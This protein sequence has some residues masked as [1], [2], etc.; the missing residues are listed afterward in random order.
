[1]SLDDL[2]RLPTTGDEAYGQETRQTQT[3]SPDETGQ[4]R[5]VLTATGAPAPVSSNAQKAYQYFL[6]KGLARHQ[7]A[8]LVGNLMQESGADLDPTAANPSGA[9]GIAQWMGERKQTLLGKAGADTLEGQL[10]H[11]WDELSGSEREALAQLTAAETPEAAALAVRRQYE[12]PGEL[13]ANDARRLQNTYA[14]LGDPR[15]RTEASSGDLASSLGRYQTA[16]GQSFSEGFAQENTA[17]GFTLTEKG[18]RQ[19][20]SG[21]DLLRPARDTEETSSDVFTAAVRE[22]SV[23][24]AFGQFYPGATITVPDKTVRKLSVT[25]PRADALDEDA[26][27]V[28][29]STLEALVGGKAAALADKLVFEHPALIVEKKG[30]NQGKPLDVPFTLDGL[31]RIGRALTPGTFEDSPASAWRA[32]LQGVTHLVYDQGFRPRG[33]NL[34][35]PQALELWIKNRLGPQHVDTRGEAAGKRPMALSHPALPMTALVGKP[36]SLIH[37]IARGLN[38]PYI[39]TARAAGTLKPT[40][41]LW[42]GHTKPTGLVQTKDN[43]PMYV[44][45]R[46]ELASASPNA[47]ALKLR[48]F[49]QKLG[50]ER[51]LIQTNNSEEAQTVLGLALGVPTRRVGGK[52]IGTQ[53][54]AGGVPHL[55]GFAGESIDPR[56]AP[57]EARST[58]LRD[59]IQTALRARAQTLINALP[60]AASPAEAD[61]RYAAAVRQAA[62]ELAPIT[63]SE[64]KPASAKGGA[65]VE[66]N[67]QATDEQLAEPRFASRVA[68]QKQLT[69]LTDRLIALRQTQQSGEPSPTGTVLGAQQMAARGIATQTRAAVA[70]SYEI[71][72]DA[73]SGKWFITNTKPATQVSNA[74]MHREEAEAVVAQDRETQEQ[75]AR[76]SQDDEIKMQLGTLEQDE[77][78]DFTGEMQDPV[79]AEE[80]RAGLADEADARR[81][82]TRALRARSKTVTSKTVEETL[83]ALQDAMSRLRSAAEERHADPER[84]FPVLATGLPAKFTNFVNQVLRDIG[85]DLTV[86]MMSREALTQHVVAL[87]QALAA[88]EP[89]LQQAT[90]EVNRLSRTH[91]NRAAAEKRLAPLAREYSDY[92][93]E[94]AQLR[95]AQTDAFAARI[96]YNDHYAHPAQRIPVVVVSAE[97]MAHPNWATAMA[98]EMGHLVQR[99]W[100]E[101]LPPAL[102]AELL[103]ELSQD[104]RYTDDLGEAFADRFVTWYQ[105]NKQGAAI[106]AQQAQA[107][108]PVS[109]ALSQAFQSLVDHLTRVWLAFR[110][111]Y[112]AFRKRYPKF[113]DFLTSS[114]G[115]YGQMPRVN[116]KINALWTESLAQPYGGLPLVVADRQQFHNMTAQELSTAVQNGAA[117]AQQRASQYLAHRAGANAVR[118]NY[119]RRANET[120]TAFT[121]TAEVWLRAEGERVR[122]LGQGAFEGYANLLAPIK[123][124]EL[125]NLQV[126]APVLVQKATRTQSAV[127]AYTRPAPG[128]MHNLMKLHSGKYNQRLSGIQ[129]QVK[130]LSPTEYAQVLA[131]LRDES[132]RTSRAHPVVKE[133]RSYFARLLSDLRHHEVN[134]KQK[135]N[136]FTKPWGLQKFADNKPAII[137]NFEQVF[138]ARQ[139]LPVKERQPFLQVDAQGV[140]S[141][142]WKEVRYPTARAAAIAEYQ[143]I[144]EGRTENLFEQTE[145][146]LDKNLRGPAF[147]YARSRMFSD[148]EYAQFGLTRWLE[149]DINRIMQTYT[150]LSVKRIAQQQ[151]TGIPR[152]QL[153]APVT[154]DYWV[155]RFEAAGL[156]PQ[157]MNTPVASLELLLAE[158]AKTGTIPADDYPAAKS[159]IMSTLGMKNLGSNPRARRWINRIVAYESLLTMAFSAFMSVSDFGVTAWRA[160]SLDRVS[161]AIGQMIDKTSRDQQRELL[162]AIGLTLSETTQHAL[163]G[164]LTSTDPMTGG[165]AQKLTEA[166]FKYNG[167]EFISQTNMLFASILGQSYLKDYAQQAVTGATPEQRATALKRIRELHPTL[168]P[169]T[170]LTSDFTSS[171]ELQVALHEFVSQA[172]LHD[173]LGYTPEILGDYRF[174]IFTMLKGFMFKYHNIVL[175]QVW[176]RMKEEP[177]L[178]RATLP[179]LTL[180][181]ATMPLALLGMETKEALR[182]K[183]FPKVKRA[184]KPKTG[185]QQLHD[186]LMATGMPGVYVGLFDSTL[187]APKHGQPGVVALMGPAVG[188]VY[189]WSSRTADEWIP[190][191]IPLVASVPWL[192]ATVRQELRDTL[193]LGVREED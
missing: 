87:E 112:K 103:R 142:G 138:A 102:K 158:G 149:D 181:A 31:A 86:R 130:A 28:A 144:T 114:V 88:I 139:E 20:S 155:Q 183:L 176:E 5:Q 187:E 171:T 85:L 126:I 118:Q 83:E 7:A 186:V 19:D 27:R 52:Q 180:A 165:L 168:Q 18:R 29:A 62:K 192:R 65:F 35:Q 147:P 16:D 76:Q 179:L 174:R 58:P 13:E 191:S 101:A 8:A 131:Q 90:Q 137:A 89:R 170:I 98:H 55:D 12:R 190:S 77:S 166:M 53:R 39:P 47:N 44:L 2:N 134:V 100:F 154:R 38:V 72:R 185:W 156:D 116:P 51:P 97:A 33:V 93:T 1:M 108:A 79:L 160:D 22:G 37:A 56:A 96:I 125:S 123:G 146:A 150:N 133:I 136:Y 43:Q 157:I 36:N 30:A 182:R 140:E 40:S 34:A 46:G 3:L 15:G 81:Q 60:P 115:V 78:G 80:S 74:A 172:H 169:Q 173:Q 193:G 61:A 135:T 49:L 161:R 177:D 184:P 11:V 129:Q 45:S 48:D 124:R 9:Y 188:H 189:N 178:L 67:P 24:R 41:V 70:R 175:R 25:L 73:A 167:M 63:H 141:W 99:A 143:R 95:Q 23:A 59:K 4:E 69:S 10:A 32:A 66:V 110:T 71:A 107:R 42:V 128:S 91:P 106:K 57:L 148:Q 6:G 159:L 26:H 84:R 109:S 50:G 111:Q 105:L 17:T 164:G 94:L 153:S 120:L 121:K 68:A 64:A 92:Q 113:E 104:G 117:A 21:E 122:R 152:A 75:D 127:Y 82:R 119:L 14:V 132:L 163:Q 151:T 145:E 54:P 162:T